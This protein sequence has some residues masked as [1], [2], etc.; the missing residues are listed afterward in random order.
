MQSVCTPALN[1]EIIQIYLKRD[2]DLERKLI[3]FCANVA[4]AVDLAEQFRSVGVSAEYIVGDTSEAERERIF[5]EYREGKIQIISSVGV[6]CEGFDEPSVSAVLVCRPVKSKA[7]WVQMNGRGLRP[8]PGKEDCWFLDFCG[9]IKR[10]GLP[11]DS[12]AIDLCA[13]SKQTEPIP[14]KTCPQC[15]S[16][17]ANYE[18]ICPFCGY[19]FDSE[20]KNVRATKRKFEEILSQ[21]QQQQFRFLKVRAVN[22]YNKCK[23]IDNLDNLFEQEFNYNPP[24]DWYDGLIFNNDSEIWGIHVQHYWRYLLEI[25]PNPGSPI[26]KEQIQGLIKREF[27]SA[28]QSTTEHFQKSFTQKN[29]SPQEVKFR[30]S[31]RIASLINYT[32]LP[33]AMRYRLKAENYE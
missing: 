25:I 27:K 24:V 15:D 26:A 6:L 16:L 29:V 4:Q 28:I 10:L 12:F 3:A 11:T 31:E 8:F 21:E 7:L 32:A 17:I 14:T 9:N 19:I 2:S 33:A 1:Y 23:P 13:G 5:E 30:V 22:A 18:K 20:K